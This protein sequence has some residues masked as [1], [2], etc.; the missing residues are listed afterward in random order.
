MSHSTDLKTKAQ[1]LSHLSKVTHL[2]RETPVLIYP[3]F[4]S[5]SLGL[6]LTFYCFSNSRLDWSI[7]KNGLISLPLL[8]S[9]PPS[10][11]RGIIMTFGSGSNGCL[12]H[13]SLNDISQVGV[14]CAE[15]EVGEMARSLRAETQV[16]GRG[17]FS[18]H[19]S[20]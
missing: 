1:R 3:P 7:W 13:G 8:S 20:R 5:S 14:A 10:Q 18:N 4:H 2:G 17:I 15:E 6:Q 12:G 16:G 9:T 19:R 11:D